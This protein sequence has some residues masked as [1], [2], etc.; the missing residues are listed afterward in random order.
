MQRVEVEFAVKSEV[1]S[2][3][4]RVRRQDVLRLEYRGSIILA[5]IVATFW[6]MISKSQVMAGD[7]STFV[8]AI[9]ALG[10]GYGGVNGLSKFAEK[11]PAS[12][13]SNS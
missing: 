6:Y 5:V 8:T 4:L 11:K 7:W 2:H 12:P 9:V 13:A 1:V 10:L 3:G